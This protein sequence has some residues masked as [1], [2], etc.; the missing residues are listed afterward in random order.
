MIRVLTIIH[1]CL[2]MILL[3][4]FASYPFL[5]QRFALMQKL[6]L[7]HNVTGNQEL[8]SYVSDVKK[9]NTS[10][11]LLET[12]DL[13][14]NLPSEEKNRIHRDR[15]WLEK[16]LASPLPLK[17]KELKDLFFHELSPYLLAWIVFSIAIC[18]L[19]L[20]G[21]HGSEAAVWL[22][23]LLAA[24]YAVHSLYFAPVKPPSPAEGLFPSREL[25]QHYADKEG[26]PEKGWKA[27]LIDNWS[28][29]Q[30]L[31]SGKFH[32]HLEWLKKSREDSAYSTSPTFHHREPIFLLLLFFGW[33]LVFSYLISLKFN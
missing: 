11:T 28:D 2:A 26:S 31:V 7:V 30:T 14:Q 1:L 12:H 32:F 27:F 4:W 17:L 23:P 18:F 8:L 5:G 20:F 3:T 6:F 13:F 29:D 15:E 21:I 16:K 19:I 24:I 25:L 33:N 9:V 10:S 22:L